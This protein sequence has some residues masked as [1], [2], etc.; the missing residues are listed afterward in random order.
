M[1]DN[2]FY[3]LRNDYMF[4]A[5]LQKCEEALRNLVAA[6]LKIDEESITECKIKNAIELGQSVDSKDCVLDMKLERK[7]SEIIDLEVQVRNENNWPERSLFYWSRAFDTI[8]SGEDY[9]KLKRTIHIGILDFTLFRGNPS[10]YAEYQ[11][12]DTKTHWIYSDKINIRILDLTKAEDVTEDQEDPRIVKWARIFKAET[13]Q[14]LE[15]L[16][17]DEEVFKKMA[18]IIEELSEDE[19]IRQQCQAREDYERRLIGQYNQ[20]LVKGNQEGRLEL[21]QNALKSG[22]SPEE[23][24]RVMGIAPE[25]VAKAQEQLLEL[26]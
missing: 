7:H 4:K 10:F 6:L 20:G 9:S 24:A 8:R 11:L 18:V 22:S 5:A 25:E 21:I 16:A 2:K 13:Y 26:V 15:E 3:G 23:I 19:K 17:G 14:Q 1:A 12:M